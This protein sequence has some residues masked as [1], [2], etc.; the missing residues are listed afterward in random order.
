MPCI[1]SKYK[2]DA[3]PG[4]CVDCPGYSS[5]PSRSTL[6]SACMC[7]AGYAQIDGQN[8]TAC[9]KGK[10]K[11]S[12]GSGPCTACEQGK[13]KDSSGPGA[14]ASCPSGSS[15]IAGSV[16][17][18]ECRCTAGKSGPDG[19]VCT[20]CTVGKYK[21]DSG[22][23]GCVAC[24]D[25]TTS[26]AGS[27]S[28]QECS[29]TANSAQ[30]DMKSEAPA[31]SVSAYPPP[32]EPAVRVTFSLPMTADEFT[33]ERQNSFREAIASV[34]AVN[35]GQVRILTISERGVAPGRRLLTK[36][37]TILIEVD[38]GGDTA[39][40]ASMVGSLNSSDINSELAKRGLP[41]AEI[42]EATVAQP[43]S[44]SKASLNIVPIAV[45][46]AVAVFV[47]IT[48]I[49]LFVRFRR[50]QKLIDLD[51]NHDQGSACTVAT[52]TI[53]QET[54]YQGPLESS[55]MINDQAISNTEP[56]GSFWTTSSRVLDGAQ[57]STDH[58]DQESE[59]AV[60][61]ST[62]AETRDQGP[63]E[64]SLM[65]KD[66][67]ISNTEPAGSFRSTSSSM[68]VSLLKSTAHLE[69]GLG[70]MAVSLR[71]HL[72]KHAQGP[73]GT[74]ATSTT[75]QETR[76]RGPLESSLM[77]HDQAISNEPAGT[78]RRE[79]QFTYN[80]QDSDRAHETASST[81]GWN[82]GNLLLNT[83][84]AAAALPAQEKWTPEL[85]STEISLSGP[86]KNVDSSKAPATG[87]LIFLM[88]DKVELDVNLFDVEEVSEDN[89][90]GP[91]SS[92]VRQNRGFQ[93]ADD[94]ASLQAAIK[95]KLK[96]PR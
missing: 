47:L 36:G 56:A 81:S 64:S 10:F 38:C 39:K 1:A 32:T 7:V 88:P 51:R 2:A 24:R 25:G 15:S 60:A 69:T 8:C 44:A 48:A 29:V 74:V 72:Q 79:N 50:S 9:A 95:E 13:F 14:C 4:P 31:I 20:L 65:I 80:Q 33:K 45:S 22:S 53:V 70:S 55:L 54:R 71:A 49:T 91:A 78:S 27:T 30:A 52:S 73:T 76:D 26:P 17:S 96:A 67:A 6:S 82:E 16:D 12:V 84:I 63:F 75:V 62:I 11:T 28:M 92:K 40:G 90:A 42:L 21:A 87:N 68:L 19:G 5:S 66:Q 34:L 23:A 93:N 43:K 58:N 37:I 86:L 18:L 3:G 94:T 46:S 83:N 57:K 41:R 77:I 35:A 61:T 59:G 85:A 89:K